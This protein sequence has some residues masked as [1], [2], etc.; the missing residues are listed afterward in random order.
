MVREGK[1]RRYI[2]K[3]FPSL[4]FRN[5]PSPHSFF[6]SLSLPLSYSVSLGTISRHSHLLTLSSF[7]KKLIFSFSDHHHL[8][9]VHSHLLSPITSSSLSSS[10]QSHF[11]SS[12]LVCSS[13]HL[14]FCFLLFSPIHPSS[15]HNKK[16]KER[17]SMDY[18]R[19]I[20][21]VIQ[22]LSFTL[23]RE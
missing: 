10:L 3:R 1:D 13:S 6:L 22:S 23:Y 21:G 17:R 20:L 7:F 11:L 18:Y 16:W 5:L 19:A 4:L 15:H 9:S 8:F 12:S 14:L 2:F